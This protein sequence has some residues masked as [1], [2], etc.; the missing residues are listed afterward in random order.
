MAV[1]DQRTHA[2]FASE[3]LTVVA[4]RVVRDARRPDLA[5]EAMGVSR[6]CASPKLAGERSSRDRGAFAR[7]R[8]ARSS[9]IT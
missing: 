4:R 9:A 5:S 8:R 3:R 6:C 2:Q 7:S 1:G